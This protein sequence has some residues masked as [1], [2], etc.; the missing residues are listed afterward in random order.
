MSFVVFRIRQI[1]INNL[2][3]YNTTYD[4]RH[5]T[6]ATIV[7]Y[8]LAFECSSSGEVK[9]STGEIFHHHCGQVSH[10]VK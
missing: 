8:V 4:I 5:T 7:N 9:F 10:E 2:T 1:Q 3:F 6:T